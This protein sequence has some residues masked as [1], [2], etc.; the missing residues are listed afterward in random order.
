MKL[1]VLLLLAGW[2][3]A[4]DL[5]EAPQPQPTAHLMTFRANWQSPALRPDKKSWAL[6]IGMHAAAFGA[7]AVSNHQIEHPGSEGAALGALTGL[8]FLVFKTVNPAM[9]LAGAGYGIF[10]YLRAR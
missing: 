5:P 10:H 4:Q 1:L 8:D 2:C 3:S 9:S 7:L 6:F